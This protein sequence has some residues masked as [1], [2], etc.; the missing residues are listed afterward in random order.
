MAG[1]KGT[2]GCGKA[3]RLGPRSAFTLVELLI[4]LTLA[5]LLAALG[6]RGYRTWRDSVALEAAGRAAHGHL[7]LARTR[8]LT[9][10]QTLRVRLTQGGA[11]E[12]YDSA[13]RVVDRT[14]LS[15]DVS[16]LDSLRLRPRTLRFNGRGQAA[17]GSL[18]LYRGPRAIR[19][20]CNFV[21]RIRTVRFR[22]ADP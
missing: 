1:G 14:W 22:L 13:G 15:G 7:A 11:L 17:P 2:G 19:V 16:R 9:R 6:A 12:T 4:A 20:V 8:A 5:A 18:Y 3:E 10:R 21:G